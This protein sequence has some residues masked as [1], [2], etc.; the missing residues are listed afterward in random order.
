MVTPHGTFVRVID[1]DAR[2]QSASS[3]DLGPFVM[4]LRHV[5]RNLAEAISLGFD[6][7]HVAQAV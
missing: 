4:D 1:D 6:H 5:D 3:Q 7:R 2:S